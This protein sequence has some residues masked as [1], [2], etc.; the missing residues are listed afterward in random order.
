MMIIMI[1][2]DCRWYRHDNHHHCHINHQHH[3][4]D[5]QHHLCSEVSRE[6]GGDGG[7]VGDQPK[8]PDG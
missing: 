3:L 6:E 4:H 5:H 2:V 1:K 8:E 7:E